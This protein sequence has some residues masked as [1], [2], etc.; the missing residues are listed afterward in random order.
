MTT[1]GAIAISTTQAAWRPSVGEWVRVPEAD[2]K[3]FLAGR[4]LRVSGLLL[5]V[6][7]AASGDLPPCEL[8]LPAG[9]V[10]RWSDD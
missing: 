10:V 3:H 5:R 9:S 8:W 4:V 1:D 6:R 2:G 7:L